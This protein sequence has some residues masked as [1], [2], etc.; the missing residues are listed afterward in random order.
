MYCISNSNQKKPPW[1]KHL[2]TWE[3]NDYSTWL[4]AH[5]KSL[6]LVCQTQNQTSNSV[7]YL[8]DVKKTNHCQNRGYQKS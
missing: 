6:F 3:K 4:M 1:K 2:Q 8:Q 5:L 7:K